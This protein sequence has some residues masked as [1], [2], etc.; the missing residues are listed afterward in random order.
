MSSNT[1]ESSF[2]LDLHF[3]PAWAQQ[4][5]AANRFANFEGEPE[6]RFERHTDRGP[7]RDRRERGPRR[8]GPGEGRRG[9]PQDQAGFSR[10]PGGQRPPFRRGRPPE[11][12]EPVMVLPELEVAV[13][14]EERGVE[15]L[16][17][18]I[19]LTGRAYPLFDIGHLILK[20]PERYVVRFNVIKKPEGQVAQP[21]FLCSMDETLWLSEQEAM[22]H[23]LSRH[24]GAFYQEERIPA[25]P[26][27]GVFT[28]VAQCGMSGIILGPPNYH[29][30]QNKLRKL[31]AERY[32]HLPFE[33][34]KS[35]V[36][37]VRDEAVVKKWV[38]DQSFTVEYLCLNV[39][40]TLK[41]GSR[42]EVEKHFR[43]THLAN[44][45]Q[46]VEFY[47]LSGMAARSLPSIPLLTLARRA[48]E[49]QR[50]FP[51]KVVTALS[52]MFASLGLQFFK[53]NKTLTHV[54]VSRPHYLD[55]SATP[56]S[57]GIKKIIGYINDNPG[58]N[59][60]KLMEALAP[61]PAG[62]SIETALSGT[63]PA[64][65]GSAA[66]AP[67]GAETAPPTPEMK[68]VISDLHWLIHQGHVI[69]FA[70][71][72]LETAKMPAPRPVRATPPRVPV[73]D[74]VGAQPSES[75]EATA[76]PSPALDSNV[77]SAEGSSDQTIP[78]QSAEEAVPMPAA[79]PTPDA[80]QP[81]ATKPVPN[82][83][84][85][86]TIAQE[87]TTEMAPAA[88]TEE[89]PAP[90]TRPEPDKA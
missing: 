73:N 80:A 21:L 33:V 48:F 41:L 70:N 9:P 56:V 43:E 38:E 29:D 28:F 34:Y 19:K 46:S 23:I 17:R 32:A 69:E 6:G 30:Y 5:P 4:P 1:P 61:A 89:M 75:S 42:A 87:A 25:D 3:L 53:V 49:E 35:R 71:G 39:P 40:D 14:P 58:T 72:V 2:D 54:S 60:R 44:V 63:E 83:P 8:E 24:F 7:R 59:R 15:S 65:E 90:A 77:P 11:R 78:V 68:A 31:H 88:T 16:A 12:H 81:D 37:I 76:E 86:N 13:L 74:Q 52:Q 50:R 45:V 82:V 27:K 36:K 66:A 64:A 67:E 26:P 47:T 85:E 20:K 84:L 55:L 22:E 51:L 62:A 79:E 18:Q 10:Q 57:E